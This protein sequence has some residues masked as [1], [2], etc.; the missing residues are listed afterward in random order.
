M[1]H[2]V[3]EIL[4][5]AVVG[6]GVGRS[7][8]AQGYQ[9]HPDKFRL[10]ALCDIDAARLAVVADEF[11][12]PRRTTSFDELLRMDDIE[13]VDICTPATFHFEQIL[14]ALSAG[15]EVVCEKPLVL[16]LAE[17]DRVIAAEGGGRAGHADLSVP[18]WQRGAKG[19]AADR[20]GDRRR[21]LSRHCRDRLETDP[22]IL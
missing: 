6:C 17:I 1:I 19:Q 7:H 12:V 10:Q 22:G 13:I 5:V 16:S 21:A 4:R 18:L 14:A 2:H 9:R 11:S 8:I 3:S 20:Y 15:K